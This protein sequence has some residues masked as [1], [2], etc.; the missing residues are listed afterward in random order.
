MFDFIDP[1]SDAFEA[2]KQFCFRIGEGRM[3]DQR[4]EIH[5]KHLYHPTVPRGLLLVHYEAV[6]SRFYIR[7][8]VEVIER[9]GEHLDDYPLVHS[10]VDPKYG[11]PIFPF[12]V[13]YLD[14]TKVRYHYC[15]DGEKG[16]TYEDVPRKQYLRL[17]LLFDEKNPIPWEEK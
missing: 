15:L 6:W 8:I 13:E 17:K 3:E 7:E 2:L 1:N 14:A 10:F 11:Q 4:E 9:H 12:I 16:C 5:Y